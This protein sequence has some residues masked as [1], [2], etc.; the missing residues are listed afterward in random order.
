MATFHHGI[1]AKELTQIVR[2]A[3]TANDQHTLLPQVL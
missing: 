2:H 1:T 3:A